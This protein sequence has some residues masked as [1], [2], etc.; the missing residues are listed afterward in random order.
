MRRLSCKLTLVTTLKSHICLD[1]SLLLSKAGRAL[2]GQVIQLRR[3]LTWEAERLRWCLVPDNDQQLRREK[4]QW[5]FILEAGPLPQKEILS[6]LSCQSCAGERQGGT[7]ASGEGYGSIPRIKA[8]GR[9]R[10]GWVSSKTM[11][12]TKKARGTFP[13]LPWDP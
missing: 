7:A 2:T 1:L 3:A 11:S 10:L 6:C 9:L 8:G 12:P 13:L 4:P 5:H